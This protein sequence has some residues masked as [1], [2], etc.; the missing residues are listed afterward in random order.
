MSGKA[1]FGDRLRRGI[2]VFDSL[3]N[4]NFAHF[5]QAMLILRCTEF[6]KLVQAFKIVSGGIHRHTDTQTQAAWRSHKH[7][8]IFQNKKSRLKITCLAE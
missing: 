6:Q 3:R 4:R 2:L 8:F 5:L 7:S 1:P